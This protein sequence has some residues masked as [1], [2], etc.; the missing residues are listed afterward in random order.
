MLFS[1]LI[2]IFYCVSHYGCIKMAFTLM[3]HHM[4]TVVRDPYLRYTGEEVHELKNVDI[5]RWSF[6]KLK[7][8]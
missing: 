2:A 4:G 5:D 3:V 1:Y 6:L 8:S 7:I